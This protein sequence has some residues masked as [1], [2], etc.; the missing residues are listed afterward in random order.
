MT[1][2]KLEDLITPEQKART[3]RDEELARTDVAATVSDYPNA[4]AYIA[5]RQSLRAWPST[6]DFPATRPELGE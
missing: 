6:S 4:D 3:W 1:L 5:Y 2:I